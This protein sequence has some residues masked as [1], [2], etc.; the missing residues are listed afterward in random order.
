MNQ[1]THP[2]MFASAYRQLTEAER[3]FVNFTVA[4][5]EQQADE[6]HIPISQVLNRPIPSDVIA[7]SRGMLDRPLVGSAIHER[8]IA[9]AADN[10]L[11]YNRWIREQTAIAHSNILDFITYDEDNVPCFD[12][13]KL[14]P[15]QGK[16]IKTLEIETNGNAMSAATK[17]KIKIQLHPKMDALKML[18]QHAGWL[19]TEN[20]AWKA[21]QKPLP[22]ALPA[23]ATAAEAGDEYQRMIEGN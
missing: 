2:V 14:T 7:R 3:D 5:L 11:S 8:I 21:S 10:E 9:L 20:V 13:M 18:G 23:T 16:A 17:T 6:A 22:D 1:M 15:E 19:E 4:L 12:L